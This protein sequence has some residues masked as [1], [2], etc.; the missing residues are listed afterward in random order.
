ML[1][2]SF[3]AYTYIQSQ[4]PPSLT[5]TAT[6]SPAPRSNPTSSSDSTHQSRSD[7]LR[8]RSKADIPAEMKAKLAEAQM[9]KEA[10]TT[11]VPK[12]Q[13]TSEPAKPRSKSDDLDREKIQSSAK[14]ISKSRRPVEGASKPRSLDDLTPE[15]RARYEHALAAKRDKE[16]KH[17]P[18]AS[19]I[20]E[21]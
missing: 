8:R 7:P 18:Q 4:S 5:A 3:F 20:T 16:G 9:A 2:M 1:L 14:G 11:E 10:R 17:L 21:G 12:L 13:G 19:G 15:Q 6:T